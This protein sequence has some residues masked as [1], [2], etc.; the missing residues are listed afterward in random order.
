MHGCNGGAGVNSFAL[1]CYIPNPLGAF[2]DRLRKELVHECHAKAHVTVL[3]PRPIQVPSADAWNQIQEQL[4]DIQPFT[5][6]LGAIEVF[7]ITDV[8]YVSV[9]GGRSELKKLHTALNSG[10]V[11]F[12]EPFLYHPHV[13]LAQEITRENV[14]GAAEVAMD[15][16]AQ[17][18][19]PRSFV[20]DK[21]TFVQNTTTNGWT[22]LNA[23][24]SSPSAARL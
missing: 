21:L 14:T 16:W 18:T 12:R 22:D 20:V 9:K 15:R 7:P 13:T 10:L 8:I 19:G 1:V 2:L 11:S 5:V 17:F 4:Q 24:N 23:W 3:P 6:E